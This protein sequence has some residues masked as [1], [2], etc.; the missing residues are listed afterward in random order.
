[1]GGALNNIETMQQFAEAT[2]G[3]A[4]YNGNDVAMAVE[5]AMEDSR[6]TYVPGFYL[7][8]RDRD[9]RFHMLRVE[10][11]R[12]KTVLRYRRGYTPVAQ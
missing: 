1:M 6:F 11:D 2:G 10:V 8:D 5:V 12:P 9:R 3:V 7:N 4:Y